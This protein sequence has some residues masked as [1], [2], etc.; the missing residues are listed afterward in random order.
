M[1]ENYRFYQ[2]KMA[3]LRTSRVSN[4]PLHNQLHE[5][6][7]FVLRCEARWELF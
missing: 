2:S 7:M 4:Q 1:S 5:L 6:F 3:Q